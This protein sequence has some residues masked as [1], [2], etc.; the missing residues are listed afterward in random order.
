VSAAPVRWVKRI[1]IGLGSLV[2]L[3]LLSGA[4]YEQLMRHRTRQVYPV[5]G[6]LVDVGGGRRIQIDC[7]GTGSPTVVLEAGLDYLGSLSW[8]AVQ[9]SIAATTRVCAYSRAGIMWSDAPDAP[10]DVASVAR[11]LHA[12]LAAAGEPAPFVMVGHSIGG[13]YV[14][15]YTRAYPSEVKGLVF[16]DASHPEQFTRFYA[17]AGKSLAPSPGIFELGAALAW[18]GLVRALPTE[19]APRTWPEQTQRLAPAFLPVSIR[20]VARE[21]EAVS[22][23]LAA[24]GVFRELGDRPLVVL[25]AGKEQPPAALQSMGLTREQG[26]HLRDATRMLHDDQTTWSRH[27]RHEIVPDAT[28]YIQFDRPDVVIRAAR[29]VV[30]AVRA[31]PLTSAPRPRLAR[32]PG[33]R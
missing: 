32:A 4:S 25:T 7:R 14:M 26:A 20:A 13:P 2:A 17:I 15:S 19:A 16:V 30:A 10:F 3:A 24:A 8:A 5:P 23:T 29:E 28:H 21:T 33:V 18:T 12:A 1:A 11:D 6:R 9:D 22:A 27:G 31:Q